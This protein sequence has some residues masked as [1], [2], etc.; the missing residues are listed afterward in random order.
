MITQLAARWVLTTVFA[1]AGLIVTLPRRN[2]AGSAQPSGRGSNLFY[3]AMCAALIAMTWRSEPAAATWPQL[4]LF[5]CAALWFGL[6]SLAGFGKG[7]RPSLPDLFHTLMAGAMM[8]ML[9]AMPSG[10]GRPAAGAMAPPM[11][12]NWLCEAAATLRWNSSSPLLNCAICPVDVSLPAQVGCLD[13]AEFGGCRTGRGEAARL[14]LLDAAELEEHI[15]MIEIRRQEESFPASRA[16]H[17]LVVG[18][19]EPSALL[20]SDTPQRRKDLDRL[21]HDRPAR[22]QLRGELVLRGHPVAGLE[23]RPRDQFQDLLGHPLVTR[24][25]DGVRLRVTC[26]NGEYDRS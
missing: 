24:P 15:D 9:T 23:P 13:S 10:T 1:A 7:R 20:S 4:A 17:P 6:T 14:G 3:G 2:P 22:A 19:I 21:A 25:V 8:W 5:G 12:R 11:S 18:D 26:H 16:E